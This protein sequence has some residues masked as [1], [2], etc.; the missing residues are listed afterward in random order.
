MNSKA[1]QRIIKTY[2][3]ELLRMN[4]GSVVK[5]NHYQ[6]HHHHIRGTISTDEHMSPTQ[7]FFFAV[8]S[9]V[10]GLRSPRTC[11]L[12]QLVLPSCL[13]DVLCFTCQ[14]IISRTFQAYPHLF[15]VLYVLPIATLKS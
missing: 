7:S 1:K 13:V 2:F 3:Y 9:V 15:S 14:L 12:Y 5:R 11:S 6:H 4:C 10:S 8:A